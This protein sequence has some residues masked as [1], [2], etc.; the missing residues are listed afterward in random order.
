[1]KDLT[2]EEF[3]NAPHDIQVLYTIS[4]SGTGAV[5]YSFYDACIKKY[6]EY[7]PDEVELSKKWESV[8]KEVINAF[9]DE[10]FAGEADI[11][12]DIPPSK[13]ILYFSERHDE[14]L[15][16]RKQMDSVQ[17]DLLQLR[18]RLHEKYYSPYG[19][20]FIE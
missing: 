15:D 17:P 16:W 1:M 7:F 8:P 5:G 2:H 11:T 3:I 13:G 4:Y 18:K 12:K 10:Y 19:I 6:P 20:D 9:W 14:Y